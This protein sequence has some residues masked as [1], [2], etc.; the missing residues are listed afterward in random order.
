MNVDKK[1]KEI[2]EDVKDKVPYLP[3]VADVE[4]TRTNWAEKEEVEF[5]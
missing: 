5:D 3:I 1:I 2:M 4:M